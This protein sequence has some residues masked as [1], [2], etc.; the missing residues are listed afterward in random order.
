MPDKPLTVFTYAASASL[1]A[2]ALVY[3]FHPNY[4]FDN[5]SSS[6]ASSRKKGI[7][8]LNNPANDCFINCNLQ[9]LAG[10]GYL[11]I[12]LIRELHRRELGGP[13]VYELVPTKDIN[14]QKLLSLQSGEVTKGLKDMIDSLNE[15]PIYRK[16]ISAIEFIRV[17][18]HAFST[19]ISKAQQDAQ[20]LLQLVAERL[21][22]E[23]H[24]GR[25]ARRRYRKSRHWIHRG[26]ESTESLDDYAKRFQQADEDSNLNHSP[27]I[28]SSET[29][30]PAPVDVDEEET[31]DEDGFPLEGQTQARVE[32]EFCHFVPK[33]KPTSFVMLNLMVPQK[34]SASL[35]DCFDAHFKT[36]YIEDYKCDKC[37]LNH[38][39]ETLVKDFQN[40]KSKDH[41]AF[42]E[43]DIE[44]LKQAAREDPEKPPRD[45]ALPDIKL[46]PRR[47][48]ARHIEIK[49]FPKVLV[50]HLSRSIFDPRSNSTKNLA[51]VT[52]PE[53]FPMG[54]LLNRRTYKLLS[55]V[56]HKGTHNSGHYETFRRQHF[57]AP[58]SNP[59][60]VNAPNPFSPVTAAAPSPHPTP[61][62]L[63]DSTNF[64][65]QS[66][67]IP[68]GRSSKD[69]V[70]SSS[71]R[72]SKTF[73]LQST[74]PSSTF[75]DPTDATTPELAPETLTSTLTSGPSE[76]LSPPTS[77]HAYHR[78][79]VPPKRPS[80]IDLTRLKRKKK[81][82]DRWWRISDDKIKECKT[83][84]VLGMTREV[85]MLFY[86]IDRADA[87]AG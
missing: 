4:L 35:N 64:E 56:T 67:R 38:A 12:Y 26:L 6:T 27:T 33:A 66:P 29:R 1:A 20:E 17:L 54:S 49:T 81:P 19:T 11:R 39:I 18:E 10:L 58:Y 80:A 5:N 7:V 37:R 47:K 71:P 34:A 9:S 8:G 72:T 83:S 44:K 52:F 31:E 68:V 43:S 65:K 41:R 73:S 24:A 77:Q 30:E 70:A 59:Y 62:I 16:T 25:D 78:N 63:P 60:S 74:Q 21:R 14:A 42:I 61:A 69:S 48:I 50:V 82:A 32:C 55:V 22:E 84:D 79:T 2:V 13:A 87:D 86:E 45:V 15:R 28:K 23:Y 3:F 75:D 36:E 53:K 40:A 51:K 46:A 76:N 85:Y 57:Y